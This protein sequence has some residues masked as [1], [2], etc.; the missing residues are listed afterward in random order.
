MIFDGASS[1]LDYILV[2]EAKNHDIILYYLPSN[3]TH[4]HQ[5][6]DKS[7]NKSLEHNRH[8]EAMLYMYHIDLLDA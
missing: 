6:L 3:T 1:H 7:V 4:E 5:P 8:Q 2:E